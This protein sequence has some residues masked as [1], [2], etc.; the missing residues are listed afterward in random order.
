MNLI[1]WNEKTLFQ[2]GWVGL[3]MAIAWLLARLF[4]LRY[5]QKRAAAQDE[6]GLFSNLFIGCWRA[7]APLLFV[8][9]ASPGQHVAARIGFDGQLIESALKLGVAWM[10]IRFLSGVIRDGLIAKAIAVLIFCAAALS[11]TGLLEPTLGYLD[12]LEISLGKSKLTLLDAGR[13]LLL[14]AVMLWIASRFGHA[15]GVMMQR[16]PHLAS[17]TRVLLTKIGTVVFYAVGLLIALKAVGIDIT[18]LAVFG[19]ALGVG[20]GLGL[21]KIVANFVS[22]I[23]LL[24]ER[25]IKPGDIVEIGGKEGVVGALGARFVSLEGYDGKSYLIPNEDLITQR[26]VNWSFTNELIRGAVTVTLRHDADVRRAME[27]MVETARG[28]LRVIAHPEP[29]C[30]VDDITEFGV[31]VMLHFWIND[32]SNGLLGLRSHILLAIRERFAEEGIPFAVSSL[33]PVAA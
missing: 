21:Q 9:L 14:T 25:S 29:A 1:E 32:P 24:M 30:F 31:K 6:R 11:I 4:K 16:V 13:G 17:T 8:I 23:T 22:G 27:I 15:L 10:I 19:G 26:V 2:L 18:A 12:G 5:A 28:Q 7:S 33:A 3:A 20:V